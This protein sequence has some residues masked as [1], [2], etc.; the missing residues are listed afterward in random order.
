MYVISKMI[1]ATGGKQ[2]AKKAVEAVKGLSWTSPRGPVTIDAES[3]HIT[4]NIYLREVTKDSS[5]KYYNKEIQTF[6]KQ[7]DPGLAFVK[8]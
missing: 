7:G 4:E 3:R 2:D 5:G 6:E 1:E 8:K